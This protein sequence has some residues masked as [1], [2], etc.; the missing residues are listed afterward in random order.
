RYREQGGCAK[1]R[2]GGAGQELPRL[3]R[4]HQ[5]LNLSQEVEFCGWIDNVRE[6]LN[7]TDIF[8]LP[9]LDEPFGIVLLEAM[10][11]GLPIITTCTHGPLEILNSQ[12]A[13]FVAPGD[14]SGLD[15]TMGEAVAQHQL[16]NQKAAIALE[17]F[18]NKYTIETVLPQ[19]LQLYQSVQSI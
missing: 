16:T 1:L 6:F 8:I 19:I 18:K 9:S 13:Y 12:A 2:I 10:A 14:I 3:L 5:D 4:L 11:L 7:Q 15:Q 17:L